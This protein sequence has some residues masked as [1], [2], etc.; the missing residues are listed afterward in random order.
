MNSLNMISSLIPQTNNALV[1]SMTDTSILGREKILNEQHSF[2]HDV[3]PK[4]TFT[5]LIVVRLSFFAFLRLVNG[6]SRDRKRE[7]ERETLL[8]NASFIRYDS[9]C[10]SLFCSSHDIPLLCWRFFIHSWIENQAVFSF[11]YLFCIRSHSLSLLLFG[12]TSFMSITLH[13]L[14]VFLFHTVRVFHPNFGIPF[15]V[16]LCH[17][18]IQIKLTWPRI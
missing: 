13:T 16:N 3:T 1:N 15:Q 2:P 8:T 11:H 10:E 14:G 7:R 5:V 9:L 4:L 12:E 17:R 6:L 18:M